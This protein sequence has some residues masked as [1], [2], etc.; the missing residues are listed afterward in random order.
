MQ[1][2]VSCTAGRV[3]QE[4]WEF[5]NYLNSVIKPHATMETSKPVLSKEFLSQFKTEKDLTA[6]FTDLYQQAINQMLEGEMD[7]HLGYGRYERKEPPAT[8]LG[9]EKNYRNGKIDKQVKTTYG[10]LDIQVPRDR[11][12]SFEPQLV[13]KRQTALAKVEDTVLSL[14]SK[15]MS[16][17]D[18]EQQIKELYGGR[19]FRRYCLTD[20]FQDS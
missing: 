3:F 6:F 10:K 18:I 15:G 19:A 2:I 12:A 17:R 8:H 4:M 9:N 7:S 5:K 20:Y 11:N 16:T 1:I 14:Y 13:K